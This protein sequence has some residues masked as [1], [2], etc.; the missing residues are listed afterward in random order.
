MGTEARPPVLGKGRF[1]LL[2]DALLRVFSQEAH[3]DKSIFGFPERPTYQTQGVKGGTE[4][5]DREDL[6]PKSKS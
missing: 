3:Q 4:A 6:T 5:C 1:P 2:P